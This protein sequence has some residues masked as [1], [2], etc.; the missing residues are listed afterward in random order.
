M[1]G[2][3]SCREVFEFELPCVLAPAFLR[4]GILWRRARVQ[5][6]GRELSISDDEGDSPV[7]DFSPL[8]PEIS[9]EP[10]KAATRRAA[11]LMRFIVR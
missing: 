7:S 2:E 6:F 11:S 1:G 4:P 3:F 8:H 9:R 5:K 10:R